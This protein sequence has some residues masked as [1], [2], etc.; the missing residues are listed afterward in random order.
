MMRSSRNSRLKA[1]WTCPHCGEEITVNRFRLPANRPG[2][3]M[4]PRPDCS[5]PFLEG[6]AVSVPSMCVLTLAAVPRDATLLDARTIDTSEEELREAFETN[7]FG[8]ASAHARSVAVAQEEQCR[9]HC[10]SV[11]HPGLAYFA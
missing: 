8:R 10:Q 11:Q 5:K 3:I 4:C 9:T 7:L 6:P 2:C 1:S